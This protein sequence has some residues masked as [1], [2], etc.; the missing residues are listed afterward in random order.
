MRAP[1]PMTAA[2][3]ASAVLSAAAARATTTTTSTTTSSTTTTTLLPHPLSRATRSCVRRVRHAFRVCKRA[4][5]SSCVTEYENAFGTCF[6]PGAG[7]KCATKCVTTEQKCLAAAP[8]TVRT[9]NA[10][11]ATAHRNDVEACRLIATGEALWAAGDASCLTTAETNLALCRFT[12]SET[13]RNC[14]IAM[15][16]CIA[17]CQNL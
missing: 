8:Q 9:C 13:A 11:C 17:N 7:A 5:G 12:C 1:H 2:L 10:A 14:H 4:K 16:F 6:S 3:V 15:T